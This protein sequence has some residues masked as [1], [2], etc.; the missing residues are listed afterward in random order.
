MQNLIQCKDTNIKLPMNEDSKFVQKT[1]IEMR[2]EELESIDNVITH[3]TE[4]NYTMDLQVNV[5]NVSITSMSTS[6]PMST[7]HTKSNNSRTHTQQDNREREVPSK[8]LIVYTE[9]ETAPFPEIILNIFKLAKIDSSKLYIYGVKNPES[10]C[11]SFML[12]N[13]IDFIIKNKNEKK[14]EPI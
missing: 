5:S 1:A 11:K 4:A 3:L 9:N 7:M 8:S 10:F 12:L 14:N 6:M 13:K 2:R